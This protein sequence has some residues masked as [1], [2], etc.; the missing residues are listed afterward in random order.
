MPRVALD[1]ACPQADADEVFALFSDLPTHAARAASV[2]HVVA[3]A[4]EDGRRVSEWEVAFRNGILRW[5]E[6]D[7]LDAARMTMSFTQRDGDPSHFEGSWTVRADGDGCVVLFRAEFDLGVATFA[8]VLDPI[9]EQALRDNILDLVD[10]LAA[11][12]SVL[13]D[14]RTSRT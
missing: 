12:R 9:A 5:S 13:V 6:W 8:E 11:G 1:I 2:R 4:D 14:D 10:T 3:L 7:E